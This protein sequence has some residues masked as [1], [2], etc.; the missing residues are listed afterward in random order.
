MTDCFVEF[1]Y[2]GV[3]RYNKGKHPWIFDIP[4]KIPSEDVKKLK[5][6]NERGVHVQ[7]T[8]QNVM[9]VWMERLKQL[10]IS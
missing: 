4:G 3:I 9:N 6:K 1:D 5:L 2:S 10:N 7:K 8:K